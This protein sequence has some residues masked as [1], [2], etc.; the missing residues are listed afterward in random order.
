MRQLVVLAALLLAISLP[1]SVSAGAW[2][3][4]PQ[5]SPRFEADVQP[6]D[7]FFCRYWSQLDDLRHP[8]RRHQLLCGPRFAALR[9]LIE[10]HCNFQV[11]G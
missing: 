5:H 2:A 1:Q 10:E 8:Q 11:A 4:D 3:V 6:C 7:P 9:G